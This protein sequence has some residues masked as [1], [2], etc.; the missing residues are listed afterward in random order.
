MTTPHILIG[1]TKGAFIL[2][3]DAAR[4]SWSLRGPFCDGSPVNHIIGTG[5]ALHAA[6]G[7][8]WTKPGVWRSGD[9]GDTWAFA[10]VG[11]EDDTPEALW[12]IGRIGK[13]LLTGTKPAGLFASDDNGESWSRVDGFQREDDWYPGAAGLVL[14]TIL[15]DPADPQKI[16]TGVSAVGAFASEDGGQSWELRN[17]LANS[18]PEGETETFICV[19]NIQRATG[20]GDRLYQQNHRGVFRSDD[21]GRAWVDITAGLPSDFGFPIAVHPRNPDRIWT[22]PLNGDSAG[23]YPPDAAAAVWRSSDAGESWEALRA[24]LPQK[25]CF[26]TVLRQAMA[27]DDDG[28][29]C[30]IAFG[31]N[32]GSIFFSGDEGD[33]WA[34]I[35]R[36]LPTVLSVE[37]TRY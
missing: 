33:T 15:C 23:R 28:T 12:S 1:T 4:Q 32:T 18:G 22:F 29:A 31:T 8:G 13:R 21:G 24:G 19:H 27:V 7:G 5:G 6:G 35:A 34:E 10:E 36:H 25:D 14:H 16:W 17:R 37:M 30:G 2:D 9:G 20:P 26:L 11:G 3:G